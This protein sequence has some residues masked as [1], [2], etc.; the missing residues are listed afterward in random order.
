MNGANLVI[1]PSFIL[2]FHIIDPFPLFHSRF[3]LISPENDRLQMYRKL[4]ISSFRVLNGSFCFPK[5]KLRVPSTLG[6]CISTFG[7]IRRSIS[8][9]YNWEL[10]LA[11]HQRIFPLNFI[12]LS[13]WIRPPHAKI[14]KPKTIARKREW[15]S[16]HGLIFIILILGV[17]S[18]KS[19]FE[20]GIMA[21]K[22]VFCSSKTVR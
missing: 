2:L 14:V 17:Y 18:T 4:Q 20:V 16:T 13:S 15:S 19:H 3:G 8:V 10:T 6:A 7:W 21:Q 22:S 9:R 5:R 12:R 11:L 1:Y